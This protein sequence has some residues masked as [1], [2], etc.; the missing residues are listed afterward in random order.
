[1]T[2][3][4]TEISRA[5][6]RKD[7]TWN[8]KIRITHKRKVRRYSTQM[9]AT[10]KDVT[11]GGKLKNQIIIDNTEATIREWRGRL[12]T[13]GSRADMM[14]VDEIIRYLT[15][16]PEGE[17]IPM[18][19][20]MEAWLEKIPQPGTRRNYQTAINAF[21]KFLGM[22]INFQQLRTSTLRQFSESKG[23]DKAAPQLIH[24]RKM[25]RE[26]MA[27]YNDD[28]VV[29]IPRDPFLGLQIVVPQRRADRSTTVDTIRRIA[30]IPDEGSLYSLRNM[31]R[32]LFLLSFMLMGTNLADL[33]NAEPPIDGVLTYQRA[34][35]KDKRIDKAEIAI[36]IHPLAQ[37]I[38]DRHKGKEKMLNLSTRYIS[39]KIAQDCIQRG[40]YIIKDYL[41]H[42][43]KQEHPTMT[44]A[45]IAKA[46]RLEDFSFYSARHTWATIARNDLNIDK[47]TVHEGLNH[48]DNATKITDVYIKRDFTRI[49]EANFKV[50]EYVFMGVVNSATT[51][52][53]SVGLGKK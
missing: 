48:V 12:N 28:D 53:K 34:K 10:D 26:A 30:S 46:M 33:Y 35:T 20:W 17:G 52:P 27:T 13:L 29:R 2:T 9:Y 3:F 32:D 18:F 8:V 41:I 16:P 38:I 11:R 19:P 39:R 6:R 40:I 37:A 23:M 51:T 44:D 42:N 14:D 22:D 5:E 43:Y 36:N 47:W 50:I 15:S 21:R 7:G 24:L 49:N 4:K 25:F 31:A 1:M 45:E